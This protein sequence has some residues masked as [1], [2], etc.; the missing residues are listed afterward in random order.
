VA[1]LKAVAALD[2][3]GIPFSDAAAPDGYDPDPPDPP[4]RL[5]DC[6]G[7]WSVEPTT[8]WGIA[9]RHQFLHELLPEIVAAMKARIE[10]LEAQA[11]ERRRQSLR[12]IEGAK[13]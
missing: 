11:A 3:D 8:R 12:V 9:V 13:P 10:R 7:I 5:A 2:D 1:R 6:A 4:F